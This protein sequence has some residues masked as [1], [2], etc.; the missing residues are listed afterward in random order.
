VSKI[1][2]ILY[3]VR[4]AHSVHWMWHDICRKRPTLPV[5]RCTDLIWT[6]CPPLGG[7][8]D[9]DGWRIEARRV[10]LR[11]ESRLEMGRMGRRDEKEKETTATRL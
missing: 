6:S 2:Q 5:I 7:D 9:G 10:F 3:G 8:I 11:A 4:R 1:S